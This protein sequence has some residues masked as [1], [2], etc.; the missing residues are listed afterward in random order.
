MTATIMPEEVL[1]NL[2]PDWVVPL[3]ASL[4]HPT[5][6][7]ETGGIYEVGGGHVAKLRWER[8]K[9]ALLKTDASLT[10]GAIAR[11]WNDVTDFS[12]PDYPTGAADFMTLLEEGI[13]L[14]SAQPGPEPDFK[15]KVA[16]ITGAGSGYE[17]TCPSR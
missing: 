10:P 3:V 14:P 15:G 6:T 5:N 13:K 17:F 16:L 2:K 8:A 7:T 11:R 12:K 4:V 1:Q 9:G